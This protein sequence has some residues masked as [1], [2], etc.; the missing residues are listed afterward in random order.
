MNSMSMHLLSYTVLNV[1][2]GRGL[3]NERRAFLCR[4]RE[5][6]TQTTFLIENYELLIIGKKLSLNL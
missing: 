4:K 6:D 5:K 1:L 2:F 3:K